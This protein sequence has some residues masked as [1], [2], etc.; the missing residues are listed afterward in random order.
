MQFFSDRSINSDSL[1]CLISFWKEKLQVLQCQSCSLLNVNFLR[2][3]EPFDP[4]NFRLTSVSIA[5]ATPSNRGPTINHLKSTS[6]VT[7]LANNDPYGLLGWKNLIEVTTEE[8]EVN[9]SAMLII[10]RTFGKLADI[11]VDYETKQAV[12]VSQ[13]ERIAIP[14]IDYFT[15]RSF[16]LMKQNEGEAIVSI[17]VRHVS[18]GACMLAKTTSSI[19]FD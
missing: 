16:V 10:R 19:L 3:K 9:S 2:S 17:K 1:G 15:K 12:N 8:K 18:N 7:I 5:G 13:N 11:R 14:G 6:S 4:F